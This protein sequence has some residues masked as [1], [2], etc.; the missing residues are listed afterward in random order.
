ML[1][2]ITV[3]VFFQSCFIFI[4]IIRHGLI[5]GKNLKD[6]IAQGREKNHRSKLTSG[7]NKKHGGG[8]HVS[9]ITGWT[10]SQKEKKIA[11]DILVTQQRCEKESRQQSFLPKWEK[12]FTW[13]KN[14]NDGLICV[15]CK[16]YIYFRMYCTNFKNTGYLN[17][18]RRNAMVDHG[19]TPAA[20]RNMN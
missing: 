15:I 4:H 20:L 12:E 8:N 9:A 19:N 3:F 6:A 1:K 17:I 16:E 5:Y 11:E 10:S 2:Y 7:K 18:L 14:I 13:L